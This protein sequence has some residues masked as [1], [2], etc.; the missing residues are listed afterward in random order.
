MQVKPRA[1]AAR[2]ASRRRSSV[3]TTTASAT[4]S[5]R[6]ARKPLTETNNTVPAPT[7]TVK[8]TKKKAQQVVSDDVQRDNGQKENISPIRVPASFERLDAPPVPTLPP[9]QVTDL[10]SKFDALA[11]S[12]IAP[13]LPADLLEEAATETVEPAGPKTRI[14]ISKLVLENFK[15]YAGI[16]RI[17]P[18]HKSFSAVVGPNGSG[19]SN[20]IDSLLFV[21][22]FRASK[23]R[24]GKISAL[25]HN[26]A[27]HSDLSSCSVEVHFETIYDDTD[28]PD[29]YRVVPESQV[30]VSRRAYKNNSSKYTI[31]GKESSFTEVTTLL[32][33]RGIDLDHKRFL[34]LQGE[35]E[36]IAQMRPKAQNEHDDGL[37]EYLEDIIGTSKYKAPIEGALQR[38]DAL[39]D[40]CQE[41]SS[42]VTI[43]ENER[44]RLEERKNVAVK[45]IRQENELTLKQSSLWQLNLHEHH[46]DAQATRE[47]VE[48]LTAEM[49]SEQQTHSSNEELLRNL[50]RKHKQAI[51]QHDELKSILARHREA[52]AQSE[53]ANVQLQEKIKHLTTKQKKLAKANSTAQHTVRENTHTLTANAEQSESLSQEM[54][55]LEQR[56]AKEDAELTRI[57]VDLKDKT[58]VF[59]DQIEQKQKQKQPW[60]Q[61]IS[62]KRSALDVARSE[63]EMLRESASQ[64]ANDLAKARTEVESLSERRREKLQE[65]KDNKTQVAEA[66]HK[67]KSLELKLAQLR[68]S[69]VEA[70]QTYTTARQRADE[71]KANLNAS[72]S[73]GA[74]LSGLT[75][76]RDTGRIDGFHGRLGNLGRIDDKYDVAIS[77][78][79]PQLDNIVVDT[80]ETGQQCI[81]HLRKN[82]LGR[83]MFILLDRLP[84]RDLAQIETPENAPR[85]FDLV[86]PREPRFAAAFYSVLQNTLVARDLEQANRIA[87]GKQR[88]RVVTLDGQLIDKSGTMSG[89]GQKVARG[90]MSSRFAPA[91]ES[92]QGVAKLESVREQREKE[93]DEARGR[94]A[95]IEAEQQ[96]LGADIPK[97]Q[98]AGRK[99]VIELETIANQL[100]DAKAGVAELER[101]V[102]GG[103]KKSSGE[104]KALEGKVA[105]LE[106]DVSALQGETA[107]LEQEISDLQERILEV[108]GIKLRTQKSKCDS[109]REQISGVQ[110]S[111]DKLRLST[112]R[113]EK[114][115]AKASKVLQGGD[116]E[117][118]VVEEEISE[119]QAGAD[120]K[121]GGRGDST[122]KEVSEAEDAVEESTEAIKQ[123]K[124]ELDQEQQAVQA[125]RAKALE[126]KN[127]LDEHKKRLGEGERKMAHWREKLSKLVLQPLPA[128]LR[129]KK[130]VVRAAKQ[131]VEEGDD[132]D[133]EE[134]EEEE[135]AEA[136]EEDDDEGAE[137]LIELN[138]DEL[139][140][141]DRDSLKKDVERLEKACDAQKVDTAV[142]EEYRRRCEEL[143]ERQ[144]ALDEAIGERDN[145]RAQA[146][147]LRRR[148][149]TE[150]MRGFTQI[151]QRLKE[152]Y[153]MITMGGNAELELVD[154]LDPFSEGILFS[155]MPPRKSWKNISNL[156][157]GE[158]T[159]SSLALVFALHHYKPTPLY[160]MDEIDAA[161]DFRNVSIVANYIKDRTRNAQFVVISLRNNM[162]ELAARL[163]GI[164]KTRDMT[165]SIAIENR[166]ILNVVVPPKVN[167]AASQSQQQ[168]RQQQQPQE[169]QPQR[170]EAQSTSSQQ[171]SQ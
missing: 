157:G 108:G 99:L 22:G 28:D 139:A 152:M 45:Q 100:T 94:L 147:D 88:W 126:L 144:L 55:D 123:I 119:L 106:K 91:Q 11:V 116:A 52:A 129:A 29:D 62:E 161:L 138:Q 81:E 33:A 103:G 127:R 170:E 17:G 42:R 110:D 78:A 83:A 96:S 76:L 141:L 104:E 102:A 13:E 34:I 77:T 146:D 25:I 2:G 69:E 117:L 118:K 31:N 64:A 65:Q 136:E 80:V 40:V 7:P 95:E 43:V 14:I 84:K 107:G 111:L 15:S 63:L 132:E 134:A 90:G 73:Q 131:A 12:D 37:L 41:K 68:Q 130:Q 82:N 149:L 121:S 20:V 53:K 51:K 124:Q 9:S 35:V 48:E 36:S 167:G 98:L 32:K 71:A 142:L 19:K 21:F 39:N 30:I 145:A 137:A 155:V 75:K 135:P 120:S 162:F 114:E 122:S 169:K 44:S 72:Q 133:A 8:A 166:D 5:T 97:L 113:T 50:E 154:S 47:V 66:E 57:R 168:Q 153:Q 56:F 163:V 46:A 159:L 79:C 59:S 101:A 85:L 89:G 86:Q 26:S 109:L 164:Y 18:F 156:S 27:T 6:S 4:K 49:A 61:Q 87:Y 160:V 92:A 23:M 74:V 16:Q 54:T 143:S 150:F 112:T 115:L 1:T 70:K 60:D 10:R 140:D 158:K 58:Q 67:F 165:K 38:M 125:F 24:Q 128:Y 105:K 93:F 151:S 3:A 171:P 148:R